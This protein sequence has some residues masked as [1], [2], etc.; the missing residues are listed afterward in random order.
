[1]DQLQI[2]TRELL[3]LRR[4]GESGVKYLLTGG[5]AL[6]FHGVDRPTRDVDVV[7]STDPENAAK[8]YVA[9]ERIIGHR[10]DFAVEELT[11]PKKQVSFRADGLELD[12]LTTLPGIEFEDA[13]AAREV[14]VQAETRIEV[15]SKGDLVRSKRHLAV[16]DPNPERRRR[17]ENDVAA[18]ES[19]VLPNTPLQPTS[20]GQ[21]AVE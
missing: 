13:F 11:K 8:L 10:P 19:A 17:E 6:R 12:V 1:M 14:A 2:P 5:Q 20:G 4:L 21:V 18:L 16:D 3:A 7:V 15:I 9:I